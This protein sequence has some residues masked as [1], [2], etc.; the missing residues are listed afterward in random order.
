MVPMADLRALFGALGFE[1]VET[2]IQSGNVIFR[3]AAKEPAIVA[4]CER[5]LAKRF[6]P[7]IRVVVRSRA[8]MKAVLEASPFAGADP[9]RVVVM[10]CS[11]KPTGTIDPARSPKDRAAVAGREVYLHCPEGLAKSRFTID[12]L[13]RTLS[14]TCTGRNLRTI[15]T[16]AVW[17]D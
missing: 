1:G 7:G 3:S 10:F 6:G 2:Y 17:G 5:V 4:D 15:A 16:L 8:R 12:Y 13:E 11:S 9:A 14:T